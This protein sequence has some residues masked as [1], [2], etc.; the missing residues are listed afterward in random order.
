MTAQYLLQNDIFGSMV[1][2]ALKAGAVMADRNTI[3]KIMNNL[4]FQEMIEIGMMT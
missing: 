1:N 4:R 2:R 3:V